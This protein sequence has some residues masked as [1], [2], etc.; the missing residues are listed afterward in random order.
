MF[1]YDLLF[2]PHSLLFS[3]SLLMSNIVFPKI[4]LVCSLTVTW[5]V[6]PSGTVLVVH[7]ASTA[8][9]RGHVC[10]QAG[11][12]SHSSWDPLLRQILVSFYS[13]WEPVDP[14]SFSFWLNGGLPLDPCPS[15]SPTA[16]SCCLSPAPL[17]APPFNPRA[18]PA[19]PGRRQ[20]AS[21]VSPA[22][23][24]ALQHIPSSLWASVSSSVL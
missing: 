20:E 11:G 19:K 22:L 2:K 24:C 18:P 23:S 6:L 3:V 17:L 15:G 1:F 7:Q 8:S 14:R 12:C 10:A 13:L 9:W 16:C 5:C 4:D 21:T